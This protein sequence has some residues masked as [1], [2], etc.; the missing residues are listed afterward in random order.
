M[1]PFLKS[2]LDQYVNNNNIMTT[3]FKTSTLSKDISEK[4]I[5]FTNVR[6]SVRLINRNVLTPND[7]SNM[8]DAI[9][10]FNFGR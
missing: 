2:R 10:A 7:E 9:L 1:A 6:G 8:I 5:N 4:D 3:D